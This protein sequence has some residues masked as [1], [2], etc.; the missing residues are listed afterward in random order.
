M[1]NLFEKQQTGYT[2][3]QLDEIENSQKNIDYNDPKV[4]NFKEQMNW[5]I[6]HNWERGDLPDNLEKARDEY[7]EEYDKIPN[8]ESLKEI[9]QRLTICSREPL[10]DIK[11]IA[12]DEIAED[13][14]KYGV[15]VEKIVKAVELFKEEGFTLVDGVN[16]DDGQILKNSL[17]KGVDYEVIC[18]E[19]VGEREYNF[20]QRRIIFKGL[21]ENEGLYYVHY[22]YYQEF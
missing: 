13:L 10:N 20:R 12:H 15:D 1:E 18:N 3:E 21:G 22:G 8:D 5:F 16:T 11:I 7:Y 2:K 4:R 19:G 14:K 6:Q 9:I 17:R